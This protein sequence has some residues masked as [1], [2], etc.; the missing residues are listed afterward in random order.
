VAARA[1][2]FDPVYDYVAG[3]ADWLA[4]GLPR[5]GSRAAA[6]RAGDVLDTEPPTCA[7]GEDLTTAATAIEGSRY[8]FC[9]VVNDQRIGLGR[10]RRSAL[11]GAVEGGTVESVM[12]AGPSTVRPDTPARE[13]VDRLARRHLNTAVVTTPEGRL[14]GVFA[15]DVGL[16]ERRPDDL[17]LLADAFAAQPGLEH[18]HDLVQRAGALVVGRDEEQDATALAG[19]RVVAD[20]L[21][22]LADPQHALWRPD[23]RRVVGEP[24]DL[25]GRISAP[26]AITSLS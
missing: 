14:L 8:G 4:Y 16:L 3:K 13:L 19:T 18:H 24:G 23:G 22:A 26:V 9:L 2:G 10:V 7:L 21:E 5:E 1:L 25:L 17:D 20:A 15:L 6:P 11:E 12:E